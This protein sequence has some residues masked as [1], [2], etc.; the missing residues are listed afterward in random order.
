MIKLL[1]DRYLKS[2]AFAVSY[3]MQYTVLLTW[4][5]TLILSAVGAGG[6]IGL[7]VIYGTE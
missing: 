4:I 3:I 6:L 5:A 1:F 2:I 7:L